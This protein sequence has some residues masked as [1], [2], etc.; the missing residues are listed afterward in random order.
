[1][2]KITSGEADIS[3]RIIQILEASTFSEDVLHFILDINLGARLWVEVRLQLDCEDGMNT[4]VTAH[5][6]SWW[7]SAVR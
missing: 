3:R 6:A 5:D 1:M 2:N 4:V 7:V